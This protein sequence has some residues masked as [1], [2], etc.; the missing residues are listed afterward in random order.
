MEEKKIYKGKNRNYTVDVQK[1]AAKKSIE[2]YK[3]EGKKD[4]NIRAVEENVRNDFRHLADFCDVSGAE[5]LK[6]LIAYSNNNEFKKFVI[7]KEYLNKKD[8]INKNTL[9]GFAI[10]K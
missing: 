2:K 1:A 8:N 10:K 6:A 4:L 5:L 3:A 9:Q 7:E